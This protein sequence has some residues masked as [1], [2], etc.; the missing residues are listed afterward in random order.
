M[1]DAGGRCGGHPAPPHLSP[2]ACFSIHRWIGCYLN[3][4]CLASGLWALPCTFLQKQ[5][6]FS[7]TLM[8]RKEVRVEEKTLENAYHLRTREKAG[9]K[10]LHSTFKL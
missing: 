10:S 2:S 5:M 3:Q 9:A 6:S 7:Q 4:E 8:K 1:L